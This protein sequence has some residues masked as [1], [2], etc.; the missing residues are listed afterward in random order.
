MGI[1][2][3]MNLGTEMKRPAGVITRRRLVATVALV[4]TLIAT[5]TLLGSKHDQPPVTAASQ[6]FV[7][8]VPQRLVDT[9]LGQPS[10]PLS[11]GGVLKVNVGASTPVVLNTVAVHPSGEG[12]LAWFPCGADVP[13]TST[14]NLSVGTDVANDAVVTP[15]RKGEACLYAFLTEGTVDV[16]VDLYGTFST[17]FRGQ[18]PTRLV[19]TR[20]AA[21]RNKLTPNGD[22]PVS[23]GESGRAVALNVTVTEPE[24]DGHL[25]VYQCD[26]DRPESSNVNYLQGETRA[27]LVLISAGAGTVCLHSSA[28]SHV[29]VDKMGSIE[30]GG[31]SEF[32]T[33]QRVMDSRGSFHGTRGREFSLDLSTIDSKTKSRVEARGRAVALNV[34]VIDPT[35]D[36]FV[37]VYPCSSGRPPNV[38]AINANAKRSAA[39]NLVVIQPGQDNKVCFASSTDVDLVVDIG[40]FLN[41]RGDGP[42]YCSQMKGALEAANSWRQAQGLAPLEYNENGYNGA[43][44]WATTLLKNRIFRH[45][46]PADIAK[47]GVPSWNGE[48][49]ANSNNVQL[50]R[51]SRPHLQVI[52]AP[53]MSSGGFAWCEYN[54]A[55]NL[56]RGMAVGW[57]YA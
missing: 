26:S 25:T 30:P 6:I 21:Q 45:S 31:S 39:A 54:D 11:Q 7:G 29:I 14:V 8:T 12:Y 49:I 18:T 43:A 16:V 23:V 47:S 37:T 13:T 5:G 2:T 17:S 52:L 38:S 22:L 40:G 41:P 50:W 10:G 55:K 34:T 15:N 19:D 24:A 33:P 48:V 42:V 9:R 56:D 3:K 28:N 53:W 51:E 44:W 27:G 4:A 46:R 57:L 35:D 32:S 20:V 1:D 36:G